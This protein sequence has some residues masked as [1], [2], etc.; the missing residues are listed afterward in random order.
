MIMLEWS[1]LRR[2]GGEIC[3][4]GRGGTWFAPPLV[5]PLN[6]VFIAHS[7][8]FRK[9]WP[10][11]F[12]KKGKRK[13]ILH[14]SFENVSFNAVCNKNWLFTKLLEVEPWIDLRQTKKIVN[15]H[16]LEP[17]GVDYLNIRLFLAN[18]IHS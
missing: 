15:P 2:E 11:R 17:D 10:K 13:R 16:S 5:A 7:K 8:F 4:E 1:E 6:P 18:R 3:W 12:F 9:Y 14:D